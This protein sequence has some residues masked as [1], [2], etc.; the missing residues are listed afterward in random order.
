MSE[1][2]VLVCGGREYPER[3]RVK[4]ALSDLV[5]SPTLI[6]HGGAKGADSA[7]SE[8]AIAVGVEERVFLPLWDKHG[9]AAGPIRN[10][11]M[12][13]AGRPDLVLAFPGGRGTADM[14]RRARAAGVPVIEAGG[15]VE[16][17]EQVRSEASQL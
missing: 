8:W 10:Q 15:P 16:V 5:P 3:Y 14:V 1:Y 17:E 2:R 12:I 6:I 4:F 9:R 7:A 13:D 11:R